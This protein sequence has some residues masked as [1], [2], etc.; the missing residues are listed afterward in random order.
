M[1]RPFLF[2]WFLLVAA[3]A[4]DAPAAAVAHP[5]MLWTPDEAAGIRHRIETEPWA[6][7]AYTNLLADHDRGGTFR[8]LFRYVVMSDRAAGLAEKQYL[9]GIVGTHPRQFEKMESGGRHYDCY[10]DALRYDSVYDLL[11]PEERAKIEATFRAY[12]AYQLTDTKT[13][14]RTSW[15]PNM[16]WPRPM[17]AHL[18]AVSLGDRDAIRALVEGNGGWKWYFDDYLAD[19]RFYME[20]FGKHYS[21]I[22]EMLLFCRG[23]ERLGLH[24]WGYGYTGKHGATMRR[25]LESILEVGY[26]RVEIPDGMPHYPKVTMGDARGSGF[27]GA[28]PYVFQHSIVM[29]ALPGQTGAPALWCGANMNGRDHKRTKVDKL[30]TPQW[31]EIAHAQWPDAG[32]DYFLAQMRER[33]QPAYTPTLFWGLAPVAADRVKPPPAPSVLAPERGFAL[34]RADETPAYWA[35]P[36]PAVALQFATYYVHYTHDCFAL[37]GFYAHHRPIYLNRGIANGY[38]GG[39]PWT[40]SLRGQCGV[41]VDN[42]LPQPAPVT[43]RHAF[44][45]DCKFVSITATGVYADVVQQRVLALTRDYLVDVYR[46]ESP[47]PH[48]YQWQVHALGSGP[49]AAWQPTDELRGTLYTNAV[50]P[51]Y[52]LEHVRTFAAGQ[53]PWSV[54]VTQTCALADAKQSVLGEAWYARQVGVCITMAGSGETTVYAGATPAYRASPDREPG[55]GEASQRPDEVGGTTIIASRRTTGTMFVALHEPFEREAPPVRALRVVR[56]DPDHLELEV[57]RDRLSV[58]LGALPDSAAFEFTTAG[59]AAAASP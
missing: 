11:T 17:A 7:Q 53:A 16:Q 47:R 48:L 30:A 19:G 39:D 24:D 27:E 6:G 55:K 46:L 49:P 15:L 1:P 5:Y 44:T 41:V 52:E 29:G 28:P 18:M 20:E 33:G 57:G 56:Q 34:L 54:T 35:S 45:P 12:I 59:A 50:E 3:L 23:L 43:V 36:A 40:D 51:R 9:L 14:T 37:L 8:N 42:Q 32:F 31:F 26:P 38:A 58:P 13:Y 2:L 22:G 25:Y 10:L 4:A 21:M